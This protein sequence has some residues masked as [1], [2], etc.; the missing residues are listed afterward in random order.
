MEPLWVSKWFGLAA[1]LTSRCRRQARAPSPREDP[2]VEASAHAGSSGPD[3]RGLALQ[4]SSQGVGALGVEMQSV[5]SVYQNH[6]TVFRYQRSMSRSA[7]C[8]DWP[9]GWRSWP[10]LVSG[11][12]LGVLLRVWGSSVGGGVCEREVR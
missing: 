8:E 12:L 7:W 10:A 6:E 9:E 2:G 3:S 11:A 5:F 4:F 1:T